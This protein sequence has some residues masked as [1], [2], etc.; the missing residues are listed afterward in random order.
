[1]K[2]VSVLS[3][4]AQ[5]DGL[6]DDFP[7]IQAALDSGAGEILIPQG[8]YL[9]YGT[10]KVHSNTAIRAAH[11][12]KLVMCSTERRK[13]G[14]FLL[15]NA[16]PET[17]N[18]NI[19]ISGG[20]WDGLN[21][22][23]EHKKPDLM[24]KTGYSGVIL[25]FV[26]VKGLTLSNMIL[27]NSETFYVRISHVHHFIIENIDLVCD[28][29]GKNQDGIHVGG[30]VKHG[31]IRKVRALSYGQTNDDMIALNA[32]DSIERVENLD[33]CRDAI[34]DLTIEDIYAECCYTI[35]RMLSV[36]APIRNI[37][38]KN[39]YGGFRYYAVNGDAARYCST[40][41]FDDQQY[42]DGVGCIEHITFEDF[43]ARPMYEIPPEFPEVDRSPICGIR[44][45]S[46]AKDITVKNFNYIRSEEATVWLCPAFYAKNI[47]GTFI[48]ADDRE[49]TLSKKEDEVTIE[50]FKSLRID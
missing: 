19:T 43:T 23:P 50:T 35:I 47:P 26:N 4:G 6:H 29:I 7:A 38:F 28:R 31:V 3:F 17:G 18:E 24:D 36:T 32:D 9:I 40:P 27:S 14:E 48:T 44:L 2:S 25:S 16:D 45:E 11:G 20:I 33:L 42:P 13:R 22:A 37:R 30:D 41:L 49:Y 15:C 46:H 8:I 10:L 21:I 5:G 1:M 34:E 12:A 39:I